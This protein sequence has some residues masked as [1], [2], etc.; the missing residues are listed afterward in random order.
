[1]QLLLVLLS[2]MLM[3]GCASA[4]SK[5]KAIDASKQREITVTQSASISQS[6]DPRDLLVGKW[7]HVELLRVVDGTRLT[8]QKIEGENFVEF[9]NDNTWQL[10]GPYTRSAGTYRWINDDQIEQTIVESNLAIQIGLVSIK[11]IKVDKQRLEFT[12]TQ[13]AAEREKVLPP[14]KPG[15]VRENTTTVITRFNR[16]IP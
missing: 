3:L 2:T 8:P 10:T 4:P 9:K 1:M 15:V 13:T 6:V 14:P 7:R 11:N 5:D 16:V 12:I